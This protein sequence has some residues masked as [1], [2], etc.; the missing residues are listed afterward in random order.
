VKTKIAFLAI[1]IGIVS[2]TA[3]AQSAFTASVDKDQ[4]AFGDY[5]QLTFTFEGS[6]GG[7]N[8]RPPAFNNFMVLSGPNQSTR[9]QIV[10]GAVSSSISYTYILQPRD[11]G[12]FTIGSASIEAENK[13]YQS[14]PI[15]IEVVKGTA[16]R[17]SK[18]SENESPDIRSQIGNNLMIKAVVDRTKVYQGEQITVSYKVYTRV[19]ILSYNVAKSPSFTGFWSEDLEVPKQIQTTNEMV[20]G[21]EYAVGLLRKLALFPQRSGTLSLDPMEIEVT[22]PIRKQSHD[23]FDNFFDNSTPVQYK[24]ATEPVTITVQPLPSENIPAGFTGAVGLYQMETHLDKQDVKTNDAV[25]LRV[26]ISGQGNLK[27]LEPPTISFPADLEKFD[28]KISNSLSTQG[29]RIAG[30]R[31]FEY[32]LIPR[33]SGDQKIPSFTFSYFDTVKQKFV[34]L[35]SPEFVLKVQRGS[36]PESTGVAGINRED[37]KLLGEDIRF[38]KSGNISFQR[39]GESFVGSALFYVLYIS[40]LFLFLL[41]LVFFKQKEKEMLDVVS[42]R[43]RN[44]RKIA[45]QRLSNAKKLLEEKKKEEFY[46]EVSRALWGYLTDRLKIPPSDLNRE[47]I[48]STL[49]QRAVSFDTISAIISTMEQCEFARFAPQSDS[50]QMEVVFKDTVQ[51]VTQIEDQLQ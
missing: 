17:R 15:T 10:N 42:L 18:R 21:K 48:S 20:N 47:T 2:F 23:F 25:T 37:V 50:L 3:E 33:H 16:Q 22:V 13:K 12:K 11:E 6:Q 26:K 34:S 28:P 14:Q 51:L 1:L 41:F 38:I 36:E 9:M 30:S 29:N 8:F 27:L 40:P 49:Q 46:A 5:F 4:V 7:K 24:T 44:A 35:R 39:K 31:T 43:S 45:K 19:Q 32:L